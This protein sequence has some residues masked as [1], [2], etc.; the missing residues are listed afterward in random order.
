LNLVVLPAPAVITSQPSMAYVGVGDVATF[1]VV[2]SDAL[3]YQ[4]QVRSGSGAW[5]NV[6]NSAVYSG[7][8]SAGLQVTTSA[9]MNN[10]QYRVLV[11][12]CQGVIESAAASLI[13]YPQA[14]PI[15]FTLPSVTVCPSQSVVV[16]VLVSNFANTGRVNMS[17]LYNSSALQLVNFTFNAG[18]SQASLLT[19]G[20]TIRLIRNLTSGVTLTNDTLARLTFQAIGSGAQSLSWIQAPVASTGVSTGSPVGLVHRL[21]YQNGV[22]T[23]GGTSPAITN[24]PVSAT[25]LDGGSASFAVVAT[26]AVSYQWQVRQGNVWVNLSNQAPYSGV[27]TSTMGISPVSSSLN[28]FRYRVL[29]NGVCPPAV[30]SNA[31]IL[32]VNPNVPPIGLSLGSTFICSPGNVSIPVSV[33]NFHDVAALGLAVQYNSSAMTFTGVSS[34]DASVTG[35]SAVVLTANRISIN[36]VSGT[37]SQLGSGSLFHLNFSVQSSGSLNWD[38]T[39]AG[40][41]GLVST[42]GQPLPL[43]YGNGGVQ[44]AQNSVSIAPVSNLCANGAPVTLQG[45]PSGGTFSGS[46]VSSGVFNPALVGPGTYLVSYTATDAASCTFTS[47][48]F[49]TVLPLPIGNAGADQTIC[50]GSSTTLTASAGSGFS[51]LWSTG[52]T[53]QSI[54]VTPNAA[55]TPYWVRISNPAGCAITDTVLVNTFPSAVVSAGSDVIVCAGSSAILTATGAVQY[56]WSPSS[57]LSSIV[58]SNPVAS[59]LVTTTYVVTGISATGC[60]TRDTVVV[61]VNP[62]PSIVVADTVVTYCGSGTG[63]L[64]EASGAVSYVWSPAIGLSDANVSNPIATPAVTTLYT[65]TGTDANGCTNTATVRVFVPRVNAGSNRIICSGSSTTINTTYTGN[66]SGLLYHW[67]PATGLS[68]A[69]VANPVA[70]PTQSTLYTVTVTDASGCAVSSSVTVIVNPS[71]S[72]DAGLNVAIAPGQSIQLSGS[73]SGGASPVSVVWSPTAGLSATNIVNPVATPLVTTMYYLTATGSNGCSRTDS[74]LVTVDPNLSGSNISG[75]LVYRNAARTGINQG[76]ISLD[77]NSVSQSSVSVGSNGAYL[78][79]FLPDRTYSLKATVNRSAGGITSADAQLINNY[80]ANPNLID[81]IAIQA[82]DVDGNGVVNS[83][84]A[85]LVI[86]RSI[87]VPSAVFNQFSPNRGNWITEQPLV[88]LQ[89]ANIVRDLEALSLGDVN[90]DFNLAGARQSSGFKLETENS[91][92]VIAESIRSLSVYAG[93]SLVLGSFQLFLELPSGMRVSDVFLASTGERVVFHQSGTDLNV[94]WF[95]HNGPVHLKNGD[96]MLDIKLQSEFSVKDLYVGVRNMSM[97]YDND[98][99]RY[100]MVRIVVPKFLSAVPALQVQCYPN[101]F[102]TFTQIFYELP[103]SGKVDVY[104]TDYTGKVVRF[105]SSVYPA[106]GRYSYELD[107]AG[108]V[109]G[110]YMIQVSF[111]SNSGIMS[112]QNLKLIL[113]R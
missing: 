63:A 32:G 98:A 1:S 53:T 33:D 31:V 82:A 44:V 23:I 56:L 73:V 13:L 100:E 83:A 68:S 61:T 8:Q 77:T 67:T 15:Q 109:D 110:V 54:S 51:Y 112:R 57:G 90:A 58:V 74:V 41:T 96:V 91:P 6:S 9:S 102:S 103:E 11:R 92:V 76:T 20:D 107:A 69:F 18:F 104:V 75:R 43:Y 52:A 49:V 79:Q 87:N 34:V 48:T 89:G 80:L 55:S 101:P 25:V 88:S 97:A 14:A 86:Q 62:R 106:Y 78:F 4:W 10:I 113:Q 22:V 95:A 36:W 71:P 50:Q 24:Q 37:S 66:S 99:Q 85:L 81:G 94:G 84:D 47:S 39:T 64:L 70:S 93:Q 19:S 2:A 72:V 105:N 28:N 65:V 46:G 17:F 42:F 21:Q 29:V 60:I 45:S 35:L 38:S 3:W 27:T 59:P 5:S 12:G 40:M 16:P 108:L 7:S 30:T 111:E 26:N